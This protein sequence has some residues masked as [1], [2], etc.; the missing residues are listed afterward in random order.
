METESLTLPLPLFLVTVART[1]R[2]PH[3]VDEA[4]TRVP[5]STTAK[6][7]RKPRA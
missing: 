5:R 2:V 7:V 1:L 3:T 4:P 6:V